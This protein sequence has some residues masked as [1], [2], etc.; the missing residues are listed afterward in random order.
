VRIDL[1]NLEFI[2]P[3]LRQIALEIEKHFRVEFTITSLYRIDDPG[4]HGAMPLRGIDLRCYGDLG[5]IVAD[6]VNSQ[7]TY[8][9]DRPDK[10]CAIYHDVGR[11]AHLHLQTHPKTE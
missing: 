10:K 2:D 9:P 4:V 8:D 5:E 11:G 1:A 6:F 3:K 7:Y